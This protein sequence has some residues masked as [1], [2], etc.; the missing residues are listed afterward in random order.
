MPSIASPGAMLAV[1]ILTDNHRNSVGDQALTA[2]LL[3]V[4]LVVTLGLL[5]LAAQMQKII[6]R[7]GASIISRVMGI[8]LATVAVDSIIGGLSSVGIIDVPVA[9]DSPLSAPAH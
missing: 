1:V 7:T 8:V 5:L 6:G 2:A 9:A 3:M 4:V